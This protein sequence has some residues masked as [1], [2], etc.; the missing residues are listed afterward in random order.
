MLSPRWVALLVL[1]GVGAAIESITHPNQFRECMN[2]C[3]KEVVNC[4]NLRHDRCRKS[5]QTCVGKAKDIYRC[6]NSSKIKQI[7]EITTCFREKCKE[8]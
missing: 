7:G 3:Q 6:L 5:Y 1:V 8:V 2:V 4:F